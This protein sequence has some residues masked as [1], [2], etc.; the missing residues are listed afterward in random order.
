MGDW[1]ILD[2]KSLSGPL[3][4]SDTCRKITAYELQSSFS[5]K[6]QNSFCVLTPPP[7]L[8][9]HFLEQPLRQAGRGR[10]ER[11]SP[12][13]LTT[14]VRHHTG[15]GM[16]PRRVELQFLH[17]LK[18]GLTLGMNLRKKRVL[19]GELLPFPPQKCLGG[20]L[21]CGAPNVITHNLFPSLLRVHKTHATVRLI[22]RKGK[23]KLKELL[24]NLLS[25]VELTQKS[26]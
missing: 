21:L 15:H 24:L 20:V 23:E 1:G 2:P 13:G 18:F 17:H 26:W 19:T 7:V 4:C 14:S 22:M 10:G 12:E 16:C 25:L 5:R 3:A 11:S 8:P 9:S 6:E